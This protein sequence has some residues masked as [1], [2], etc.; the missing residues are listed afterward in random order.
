MGPIVMRNNLIVGTH[1]SHAAVCRNTTTP[2]SIIE[3]YNNRYYMPELVDPT[4]VIRWGVA[5][6]GATV[7]LSG[8]AS[9]TCQRVQ[10]TRPWIAPKRKTARTAQSFKSFSRATYFT[11]ASC[12]PPWSV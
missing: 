8:A 6:N 1:S 2:D 10:L 9:T 12:G 3:A 4:K 5:Q 11:A 7:T